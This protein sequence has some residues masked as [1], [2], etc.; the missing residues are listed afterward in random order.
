MLIN[1]PIKKHL[2]E[3]GIGTYFSLTTVILIIVFKC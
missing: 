1:N 2:I 3:N